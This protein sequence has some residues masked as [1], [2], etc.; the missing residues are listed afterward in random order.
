MSAG[1]GIHHSEFNASATQPVTLCQLW[2]QP[3]QHN[4][5]PRYD[6]K[7]F[8]RHEKKNVW[9]TIVSSDARD[10]SMMIYQDAFITLG[11]RDSATTYTPHIAGNGVF[12]MCIS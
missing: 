5:I 11:T 9:T 12:V 8:A 3:N 1:D 7:S 6:Q 4:I 2:I 10:G